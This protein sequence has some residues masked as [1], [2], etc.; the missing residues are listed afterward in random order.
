MSSWFQITWFQRPQFHSLKS[1]KLCFSWVCSVL[2]TEDWL[3]LILLWSNCYFSL[4]PP[5][6]RDCIFKGDAFLG[7]QRVGRD[8]V[9][10]AIGGDPSS[11]SRWEAGDNFD[12]SVSLW[13]SG[14][15]SMGR[16]YLLPLRLPLACL[17]ANSKCSPYPTPPRA[18]PH[19]F[20]WGTGACVRRRFRGLGKATPDPDARKG[21][22]S[23]S[24]SP[25]R[26]THV[27][28]N[29]PPPARP[30]RPLLPTSRSR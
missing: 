29:R 2:Q 6:P 14:L 21:S 8:L 19:P 15:W 18:L 26:G 25:R 22:P 11:A 16:F 28:E 17:R 10:Q 23:L 30:F 3:D 24:F 1:F 9:P 27:T 20:S 13:L 7:L 12:S 5:P 4:L